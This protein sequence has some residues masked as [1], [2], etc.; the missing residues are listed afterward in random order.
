MPISRASQHALRKSPS[1]TAQNTNLKKIIR[2]NNEENLA[3][4]TSAPAENFSHFTEKNSN[5]RFSIQSPHPNTLY[6]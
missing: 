2:N 1:T 3:G 5:R 4:H 6:I